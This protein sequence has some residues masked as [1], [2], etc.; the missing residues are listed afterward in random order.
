M[1]VSVTL[2][3]DAKLKAGKP[4]VMDA[5]SDV[6]RVLRSPIFTRFPFPTGGTTQYA[7]A[8]L[9]T[10]FAGGPGWH[11]LLGRPEVK[12]IRVTIP[13][14]YGYI[15][16]SKASDRSLAVVDIVYLQK[17]IFKQIP[18]QNGRLVLAVTHNT[19]YYTHNDATECCAWGTHGVDAATGNSFVLATYLQA[20]PAIVEDR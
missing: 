20:A 13:V 12:S 1:L 6:V 2:A 14:G 8:M 11:T 5:G 4:F 3:F 17:E 9:R 10:T 15:L 19:T 18:R 7:D 16:T